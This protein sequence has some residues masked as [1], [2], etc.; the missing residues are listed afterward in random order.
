[1]ARGSALPPAGLG[2]FGR[3]GGVSQRLG[4]WDAGS[5]ADRAF[6]CLRTVDDESG[7]ESDEEETYEVAFIETHREV[8]VGRK[9][10]RREFLVH[11]EG[12]AE[13][14]WEPETCLV[15]CTELPTYLNSL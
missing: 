6:L 4:A 9:K 13:P 8:Q 5:G 11:W 10:K 1:M 14:S 12:F 2:G 7:G 3:R 15:N